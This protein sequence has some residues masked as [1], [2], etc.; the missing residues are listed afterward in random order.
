MSRAAAA[1][2]VVF[3]AAGLPLWLK[4]PNLEISAP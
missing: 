1:P 3:L 4:H 2:A